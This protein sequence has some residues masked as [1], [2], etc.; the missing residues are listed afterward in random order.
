MERNGMQLQDSAQH[1]EIARFL[2]ASALHTIVL[3]LFKHFIIDY[4]EFWCTGRKGFR[5]FKAWP[6]KRRGHTLQNGEVMTYKT[7]RAWWYNLCARKRD[8]C[9]IVCSLSYRKICLTNF[10]FSPTCLIQL[11]HWNQQERGL[12]WK[13]QLIPLIFSHCIV[14]PAVLQYSRRTESISR[15]YMHQ[16]DVDSVPVAVC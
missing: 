3:G 15:F 8:L 12:P 14:E 11:F 5:R 7:E 16:C 2:S 10:A 6:Y 4:R 1:N 13:R 9:L